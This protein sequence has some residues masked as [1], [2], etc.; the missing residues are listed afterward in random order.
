MNTT[1]KQAFISHSSKDKERFVIDFAKKL[2]EN[3]VEAWLDQ[4]ELKPGDSLPKEIFEAIDENEIFI[5]IISKNSIESKW[6]QEELDAAFIRK[7]EDNIKFI[8]I[9]IDKD[10]KLPPQCR[11]LLQIRIENLENYDSE[12]QTL[13]N[14]VFDKSEKPTLGQPPKYAIEKPIEGLNKTDTV[15]LKELGYILDS[16]S[17]IDFDNV[18][19]LLEDYEL[20]KETISESLECLSSKNLLSYSNYCSS[21]YPERNT[22]TCYG[23]IL[24]GEQFVSN[25]ENI[26]KDVVSSLL[27]D[28]SYEI[29]IMDD[30]EF[31]KYKYALL[32]YFENR[33]FIENYKT[34][35]G[36]ISVKNVTGIGKRNLKKYL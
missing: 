27:N 32:E 7:I 29:N 8:P 9:I 1:I 12:F 24:H 22:L 30:D 23:I 26:V 3:R 31:I 11:H 10:V 21:P 19:E 5:S 16:K 20:S 18:C 13:I 35:D 17:S 14:G 2:Y 15:I 28:Y 36:T 33:G 4:W 34:C 25:F 6:V